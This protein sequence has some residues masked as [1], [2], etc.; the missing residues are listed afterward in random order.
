[1]SRFFK[2]EDTDLNRFKQAFA[3]LLTTRGIP[4]IY[5]GTELL[6]YGE[7]NEGDGL[8]RKD[9]PG[10]WPE[11]TIDA[12]T[13]EGRTDLQNEAHAYLQ[14]LLQWRKT[15]CA[16]TGGKLI[17][18]APDWQTECY[19][20]V[21]IKDNDKVLVMLNGSA[22]EQRLSP[23]KYREAIGDAGSGKEILSG[24]LID[25]KKEIT[26]PA[27]GVYIIEL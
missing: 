12:F 10:G 5:Y 18:Y 4:Q 1:M 11:D 25:L 13:A 23:E 19:V 22:K 3:F 9:F 8:L 15:N 26:I 16:V 2:K 21:R 14:K 7:K 20:Y 17:H 6:M 27:K 24:Q